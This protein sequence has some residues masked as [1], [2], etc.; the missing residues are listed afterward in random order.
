MEERVGSEQLYL[1][2]WLRAC[3]RCPSTFS[4]LLNVQLWN[5]SDLSNFPSSNYKMYLTNI[6]GFIRNAF[7]SFISPQLSWTKWFPKKC[8]V[9]WYETR[10]RFNQWNCSFNM[11][12]LTELMEQTRANNYYEKHNCWLTAMIQNDQQNI[13]E[14]LINIIERRTWDGES[15]WSDKKQL[16]MK[17]LINNN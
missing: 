8:Y 11:L 13:T 17:W 4:L 6:S 14:R 16:I 10:T 7:D 3:E 5:H 1:E 2:L 9:S 15:A 12:M